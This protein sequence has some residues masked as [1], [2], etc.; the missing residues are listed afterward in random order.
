MQRA[1]R[2]G[3][4][5]V[6]VGATLLG[7]TSLSTSTASASTSKGDV[8]VDN[9]GSDAY[10]GHETDP[11]LECAD[12][13]IWAD[14]LVT[15]SGNFDIFS[16]PPSNKKD[17]L[18]YSGKWKYKTSTGGDQIIAVV[19][20]TKL[21]SSTVKAGGVEK[22]HGY[23]FKLDVYQT[24]SDTKYKTFWVDCEPPTPT[25]T[26]TPTATPTSTPEETPTPTPTPTPT[27]TVQ[28]TATATATPTSSGGVLGTS[29][30][31]TPKPKS[32]V[33]AISTPATGAG[34]GIELLAALFL[35][36]CGSSLI[37]ASRLRLFTH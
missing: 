11:M 10:N 37:V 20:V 9:V 18:V 4:A 28:P 32:S 7:L 17:T 16:I 31:P 35:I 23:H 19:D 25:P 33:L 12:I 24:E 15:S 5:M 27:A 3:A 1:A 14:K 6:V 21:I 29:A 22:T 36:L 34:S 8:W 26:P 2:F 30:T 13:D